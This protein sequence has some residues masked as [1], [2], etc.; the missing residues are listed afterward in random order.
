MP[1]SLSGLFRLTALCPITARRIQF[2][3][4][5]PRGRASVN[6]ACT[7]CY[8]RNHHTYCQ[9]SPHSYLLCPFDNVVDSAKVADLVAGL[10]AEHGCQLY[11]GA[12]VDHGLT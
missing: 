11:L 6:L 4:Q 7:T 2:V 3:T 12:G 10:N 1:Q 9:A 5:M 8:R